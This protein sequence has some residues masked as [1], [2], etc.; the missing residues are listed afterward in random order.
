MHATETEA[1]I[2]RALRKARLRRGKSVEE[3]SRETRV[4]PEYLR[5]LEAESFDVL[6][7]D[8]YVRGFLRSYARYLGLSP[9]KVVSAY[10]RVYGRPRSVAVSVS[11][12]VGMESS[13]DPPDTRRRTAWMLAAGAALIVLISAAA[14]GLISR[15][16]STPEPAAG[17]PP[18]ISA[19]QSK[20]QVDML[21]DVPGAATVTVDGEVKFNG[22]LDTGEVHSF[23]GTKS[24]EVHLDSG[25]T[26]SLRVNGTDLETP[27]LPGH[28]YDRTFVPS[29]FRSRES[30]PAG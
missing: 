25:N 28:E 13:V 19:R 9:D 15:S 5:A 16:A 2:G 8:V 4:K 10:E 23:T 11:P 20:V 27:G 6:L 12:A 17:S 1:G 26:V 30:A 22:L 14:I 29:D 18:P 24:I 7:G 3:A 21:A